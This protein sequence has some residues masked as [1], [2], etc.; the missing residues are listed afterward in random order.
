MTITTRETELRDSAADPINYAKVAVLG[1]AGVGKTSI[2]RVRRHWNSSA[3]KLTACYRAD[4]FV[5]VEK[6][7]LVETTC[8]K[9]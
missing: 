1:A 5:F 9:L 6:C 8:L 3:L 7:S 2:I 4:I